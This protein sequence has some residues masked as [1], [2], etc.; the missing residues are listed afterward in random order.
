MDKGFW[1]EIIWE[2]TNKKGVRPRDRDERRI[3]AEKGE[4]VL[5][6]KR[7]KRESKGVY[8]EAAEE[9]VYPTVQ[10]TIDSIGIFCRK[11]EWKEAYSVRL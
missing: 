11:E 1:K 2:N 3:C 6:V 9:E 10:I 4:G 5:I 8:K 7:G